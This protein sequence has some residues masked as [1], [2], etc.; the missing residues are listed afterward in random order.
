V[1]GGSCC[2]RIAGMSGPTAVTAI[3][4]VIAAVLIALRFGRR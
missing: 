2:S 4:V 1:P 3:L